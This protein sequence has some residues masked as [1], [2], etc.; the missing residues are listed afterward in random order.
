MMTTGMHPR[1]ARR[2]TGLLVPGL[3]LLLALASLTIARAE[4]REP[5]LASATARQLWH[6]GS[7]QILA[8]DFETAFKTLEQ[9]QKMEPGHGEVASVISWLRDARSLAESRVKYRENIYEYYVKQTKKAI[10]EA[11]APPKDKPAVDGNLEAKQRP[12]TQ[13]D[14]KPDPKDS[15]SFKWSKALAYAQSAMSNAEDE[16][17]F[18]REP[19]LDEIVANVKTEIE[20]HK[21]KNEWRD[22][23]FLFD[24]LHA[25][26]PK[27]K[28]YDDGL[29]FCSKRAHL[30]FV[31]GPKSSWKS[32]IRDVTPVALNQIIDRVEDD[33]VD[34]ADFPKLCET[35][36]EHLIIL[37]KA[38]SISSTF[39]TLGDKDLV[40]HFL[41]RLEGILRS[42]VT[43]R[44]NMSGREV[45]DVFNRILE[46]NKNSLQ[47]P[48]SV[49]VDEFVSGM[50]EPLDEFTS[51]IWP[52]AVEDFNKHTRGE[53]VGVGIQI[54]QDEGKPV[55]VES[56]LEDSPA[57]KAGIK[58]GDFIVKVDGKPTTDMGI[59]QA[60]RLITGEPN[61]KVVLTIEDGVTRESRDVPLKRE[62]I[63]M[64]TV[65]GHQR[66][67][68]TP[69]GWDY[70][71]DPDNKIAYV[72]VGGFM[73]RTVDDLEAA[74]KQIHADGGRGV[75]LDLRYNPGGL[76]T[77]AVRMCELVLP[78]DAAIV[79]TK[80]RN[81]QQNMEIRS[82]AD[83]NF[84]DLPLIILVNGYSASAS[85]IVAGAL[86]GNKE[87][88][89]VGTRTFGKGSVQNLIPI[90]DNQA[91]LKLTTAHYFV[92]DADMREEPWYLLHRKKES[93]TWG[94]EPHV[95]VKVIPHEDAKIL[96]LRR[97][98][99]LL[100]GKDQAAI[101]KEVLERRA[102][103]QPD[104]PL[105]VDPD[106][107]VDPQV[108]AAVNMMRVKLMSHQPWALAPRT[109]RTLSRAEVSTKVGS[110][111]A[112]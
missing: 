63:K 73:D 64:R 60:V 94:V 43:G 99:D 109:Q 9:V 4:I 105:P 77:S 34:R 25:I 56:P 92:P 111:E 80:G 61:T 67:P 78:H 48:E 62:Q 86:S 19:W 90:L 35:A 16:D 65:R 89:I 31:Y 96:R 1:G 51:V 107:N 46:A 102:S 26:Y 101:P 81:K 20:G 23:Y 87:A 11:N 6:E 75:I 66:V 27:D 2:F 53:F 54:T 15:Q 68:S 14:K 3:A 72:R 110:V 37:A 98:T 49:I 41:N 10:Q 7:N 17:A 42:R 40:G 106:P 47:L 58:P 18:R 108:V 44:K 28:D 13:P 85:E 103:S 91:Y 55:R 112:R 93:T 38:E 50:F 24:I 84:R 22:A 57:Y 74:L 95:V 32:E 5:Q 36:I 52:A 88:C 21:K 33:Y 71:I 45:R 97:E 29:E 12:T 59:N 79:Q 83:E 76:L 104:E 30:D 82:K 39:P 70:M 100:K 8:G 69:T